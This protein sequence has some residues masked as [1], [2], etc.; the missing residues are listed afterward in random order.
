MCIVSNKVSVVVVVVVV[1]EA[2]AV[3]EEEAEE[4][5]KDGCS[6]S[7]EQ[8]RKQSRAMAITFAPKWPSRQLGFSW[9]IV[10]VL[11][12]K[13]KRPDMHNHRLT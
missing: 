5:D 8:R 4:A 3:D 12:N 6:T 9:F 10:A 1:E 7:K 13:A 11:T 2:E